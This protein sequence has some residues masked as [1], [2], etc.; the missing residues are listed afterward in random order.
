M[1]LEDFMIS[2]KFVAAWCKDLID[3]WIKVDYDS[4]LNIFGEMESYYEDPF[5]SPGSTTEDIQGYWE[6][7]KYQKINELKMEPLV[8]ENNS[9]VIRWYL[10][11]NDT[12][13]DE[14][15]V[16]DGIYHIEFNEHQK[17]KKFTQWW[18]LKE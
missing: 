14:H 7:I 5:S 12:R 2:K 10:D 6:E 1:R 15:F 18:V 13:T 3:S 16:M 4:I 8:I 11:Y 17:C 9:A